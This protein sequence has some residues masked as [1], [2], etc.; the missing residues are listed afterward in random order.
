M[1]GRDVVTIVFVLLM[2]V[3]FTTI[4]L[5][6]VDNFFKGSKDKNFYRMVT[7]CLGI[8]IIIFAFLI[9]TFGKIQHAPGPQGPIGNRGNKGLPGDNNNYNVCNKKVMTAGDKKY[10]ILRKENAVAKVPSL[11]LEDNIDISY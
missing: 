9:M 7:I 3:F 4:A 1:K 8:N 6:F 2:L 11:V 5:K 10:K